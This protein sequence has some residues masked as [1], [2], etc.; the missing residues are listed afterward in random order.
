MSHWTQAGWLWSGKTAQIEVSKNKW[1]ES[2]RKRA[3]IKNVARN[4][5]EPLNFRSNEKGITQEPQQ[6]SEKSPNP[7]IF[8]TPQTPEMC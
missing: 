4:S 5:F 2:R 8:G 3:E 6:S 7:L 1:A